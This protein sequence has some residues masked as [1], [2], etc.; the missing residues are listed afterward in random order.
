MSGFWGS[1]TAAIS[2]LSD[3][4][5][6]SFSLIAL[7]PISYSAFPI[8]DE[9]MSPIGHVGNGATSEAAAPKTDRARSNGRITGIAC[10][11][12]RGTGSWLQSAVQIR[13]AHIHPVVDR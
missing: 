2:R 8:D 11:W 13:Q 5:F 1:L 9:P 10:A 12:L 7:S 4:S 3:A 6:Q